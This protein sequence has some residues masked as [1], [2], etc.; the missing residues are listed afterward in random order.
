MSFVGNAWRTSVAFLIL[1]LLGLGMPALTGTRRLPATES[2]ELARLADFSPESMP[3]GPST[4]EA[5][6]EAPTDKGSPPLGGDLSSLRCIADP[7]PT[8]NGVAVDPQNN[9]VVMSDTN[10]K[11]LLLYDRNGGGKSFGETPPLR[12]IAGPQTQI[13]FVA[14]VLLDSQRREVYSVNNDIEDTL[15]VF[16]YDDQ[17]NA[18]PKRLLAVPHQSYA[19]GYSRASDEIAVSVQSLD[20]V[21]FYRREAKGV[22]APV[23]SLIGR[24]TGLAD[25]HGLYL[26]DVNKEILVANHGNWAEGDVSAP[27]EDDRDGGQFQNPSIKVF[28]ANASGNAKPI[29]DIAGPRTGLNW[30]MQIAV[31]TE[32]NEIAVANNGDHSILI[33]R[34]TDSGDVAPV[35][36]LSGPKTSI[37]R[38][39]GVAIDLRNNELWVANFGDHTALV[40]DLQAKGNAAPKR[41]IRNAPAGTPTIGFG[42]PMAAAYDT[43]RQEILVPN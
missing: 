30:P 10:R 21:V 41:I 16:S 26:D 29:R 39:M 35:R 40:F 19:I 3:C 11:S 28:A 32:H 8:F 42:N 14:G 18:T 22:E 13:G 12:Q 37:N 33:F 2:N 5:D 34:R 25:P 38:P 4:W 31:D 9:L 20:A 1:A 17:G 6:Q 23:R 24:D 15:T 7:Y 36:V 43:R 27:S